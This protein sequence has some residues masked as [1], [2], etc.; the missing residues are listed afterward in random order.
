MQINFQEKSELARICRTE[1]HLTGEEYIQ[2]R[3]L[4]IS[5]DISFQAVNGEFFLGTK[6]QMPVR[7]IQMPIE[8][9]R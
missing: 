9:E 7:F 5:A 1:Y 3:G 6:L 2:K 4:R 8:P